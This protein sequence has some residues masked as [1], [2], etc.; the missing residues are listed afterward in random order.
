MIAYPNVSL[1]SASL[2]HRPCCAK[3]TSPC[4]S[5]TLE[6][7]L[8][9]AA[10]FRTSSTDATNF[11]VAGP[12][13]SV[14]IL[15]CTCCVIFTLDS[16]TSSNCC[17]RIG[18]HLGNPFQDLVLGRHQ[19]LQLPAQ[20]A[21]YALYQFYIVLGHQTDGPSPPPGAGRPPH[22][23][24]VVLGIPEA[25]NRYTSKPNKSTFRTRCGSGAEV[26]QLESLRHD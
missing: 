18:P 11:P 24:D 1:C 2:L 5:R 17:F 9:L 13:G 16:G 3:S 4:R 19:F 15:H 23:V 7:G 14:S 21:L 26:C 6:S 22:P 25:K 12:G 20:E 8:T 10:P